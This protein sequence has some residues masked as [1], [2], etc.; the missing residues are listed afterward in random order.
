MARTDNTRRQYGSKNFK[1]EGLDE[2]AAAVRAA[3]EIPA[4]V[5]TEMINSATGLLAEA[6]AK[7]A[8]DMDIYDPESNVH[9]A[10][11]IKTSKPNVKKDTKF[12]GYVTVSGSRKRGEKKTRTTNSEIAFVN[13]YGSKRR[14]IAKRMFFYQA[15]K[16]NW[17]AA[18]DAASEVFFKWQ[19]KIFK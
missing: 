11:K 15:A 19:D 2:L 5:K 17:D 16:K 4:D 6:T 3:G 12:W 10:D 1:Y 8:R 18:V 9:I 14:G 7:T 13:E